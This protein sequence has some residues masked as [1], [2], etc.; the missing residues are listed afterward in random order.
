MPIS[1]CNDAFYWTTG[2]FFYHGGGGEASTVFEPAKMYGVC[3]A[4]YHETLHKR[5]PLKQNWNIK[6][7]YLEFRFCLVAMCGASALYYHL[8]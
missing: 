7:Q 4:C 6:G 2:C 8:K 3:S 5:D 1:R